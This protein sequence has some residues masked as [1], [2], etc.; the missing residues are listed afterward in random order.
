MFVSFSR[1]T[2]KKKHGR[3]GGAF[4]RD[5]I[6]SHFLQMEVRKLCLPHLAVKV[7]AKNM[8]SLL[9]PEAPSVSNSAAVLL[10]NVTKVN[11]WKR[12]KHT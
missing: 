9:Q 1:R 2:E 6:Q 5:S 10:S 12:P 4:R 8:M 11:L 7:L 3:G